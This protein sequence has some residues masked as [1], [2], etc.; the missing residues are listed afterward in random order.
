[1][2]ALVPVR[3]FAGD[4]PHRR[5]PNLDGI[6]SETQWLMRW[7]K[8]GPRRLWKAS[9][10]VGFS[11]ITVRDG[12]VFTMG[13]RDNTD[14][15]FCLDA[16]SGKTLWK[17]S[18]SCPLDA[19]FFEGGPTSTPTV[20]GE[21][22]YTLSRQGDLFCFQAATGKIRWHKNV[23]KLTGAPVPGWG[24]ASSPV[25]H[26]DMLLLNVG[27]SGAAIDKNTGNVMWKSEAREAGYST[28]IPCKAGDTEL[29]I[30]TSGRA[31]FAVD[32]KTGKPKWQQRWLT[33]FGC[34]AAD[35][36]IADGQV[37]ISAGYN[38][39]AALFQLADG[40]L[41]WKNKDM[42]N[43]LNSCV[44]I[45][46]C[47][48]GFHG[49]ADEETSLRC[50]E[51]KTG[52]LVW[53]HSGLGCG[54]LF[55]AGKKLIVLSEKGELLVAP[56]SREGFKPS[57]RAQVLTGKCWTVPVLANGRFYCR[58]AAGDVVCLD[59]RAGK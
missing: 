19:R 57:A 22:V 41:V 58:N 32:I 35:P 8:D 29:A 23:A 27:A 33:R 47:L 42:Q 18:Y 24:F 49:N 43:H 12:R 37:F 4:W 38:R 25:V 20:D 44:L 26:G 7:P 9:V 16:E 13:N 21:F 30:V 51:W 39:G 5:G 36:I 50:L 2:L 10:G 6:S 17:H 14:S 52:K 46:G 31:V 45:D 54:S 34:N 59:V 15:V 53:S 3:V 48:Y 56:A 40:S 11:S 1:M 28:P 55:A